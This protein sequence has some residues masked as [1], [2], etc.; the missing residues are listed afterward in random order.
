MW[1]LISYLNSLL[2]MSYN[3]FLYGGMLCKKYV[4]IRLK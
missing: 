2:V 1:I 3:K 4:C